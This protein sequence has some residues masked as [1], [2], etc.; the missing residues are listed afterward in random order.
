MRSTLRSVCVAVLVAAIVL[1]GTF[2]AEISAFAIW[3]WSKSGGSEGGLYAA[4]IPDVAFPL[5]LFAFIVT[6]GWRVIVMTR[7]AVG[8]RSRPPAS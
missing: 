7:R 1:V 5:A 3:A 4:S 6:L 8:A 2:A